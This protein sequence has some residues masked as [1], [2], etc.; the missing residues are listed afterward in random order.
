[1][2]KTEYR[3]GWR[4]THHYPDLTPEEIEEKKKEVMQKMFILFSKRNKDM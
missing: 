4:I 2:Q 1:M 3:N